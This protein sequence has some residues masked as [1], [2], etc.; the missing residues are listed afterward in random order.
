MQVFAIQALQGIFS[1]LSAVSPEMAAKFAY[2][3]FRR[4][5]KLGFKT[6]IERTL[7]Q[8]A[9]PLKS[10][11]DA[12]SV[13]TS[14][15][16]M[17]VY[18]WTPDINHKGERPAAILIHGWGG[19]ALYMAQFV[20]LLLELGFQVAAVDL[21]GHGAS[22]SPVTTMAG[23]TELVI[24]TGRAMGRADILI[25]HSFGTVIA[26]LAAEGGAP[27]YT[28]LN[29]KKL[30]LLSG[31]ASIGGLIKDAARFLKLS[32]VAINSLLGKLE[33]ELDRPVSELDA[34]ELINRI[35]RPVLAI[36]DAQDSEV[37]M[38]ASINA[39]VQDPKLTCAQTSGLGHRNILGS[40]EVLDP[41]R[42]FLSTAKNG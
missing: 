12:L 30:I 7:L 29:P 38:S 11:A 24:A 20:P 22:E 31:P 14:H 39:H 19:Q 21:P 9:A 18:H 41:I 34:Q 6:D 10:Q 32:E 27:L 13:V 37:P 1:G 4:P 15:G 25:G 8:Q 3:G 33:S 23:A 5:G 40:N 28:S 42:T 36:H 2:F 26:A 35:N 17:R 16:N